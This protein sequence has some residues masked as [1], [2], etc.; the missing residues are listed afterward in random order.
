[1]D[2]KGIK[3]TLKKSFILS[4]CIAT[5]TLVASSLGPIYSRLE[6]DWEDFRENF[7]V[8]NFRRVSPPP[9]I[10]NV[11]RVGRL[12]E[13]PLVS[14][15]LQ[16]AYELESGQITAERNSFYPHIGNKVFTECGA[17][18]LSTNYLENVGAIN[19]AKI[20]AYLER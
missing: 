4:A 14:N 16:E 10:G 20:K 5:S 19:E 9:L 12:T 17:F 8:G 1:M 13:D 7:E 18:N 15:P 2:K 11:L 6:K 3:R